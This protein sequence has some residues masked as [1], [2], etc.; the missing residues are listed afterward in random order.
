[1]EQ[2]LR[3]LT[4][5]HLGIIFYGR[6]QIL[7]QNLFRGSKYIANCGLGVHILGV[8]ILCDRTLKAESSV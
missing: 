6:E 3:F 1:M 7:Q 8:Q 4:G 5:T 2:I